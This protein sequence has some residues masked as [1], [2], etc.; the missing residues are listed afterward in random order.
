MPRSGVF[1]LVLCA[2]ATSFVAGAQDLAASYFAP[3]N[4]L[5]FKAVFPDGTVREFE[6]QNASDGLLLRSVGGWSGTVSP[7]GM[8]ELRGAGADG[9]CQSWTYDR[10]RLTRMS[11]GG[12]V[13]T[14][15]YDAPRVAPP[16]PYEPL[17]VLEYENAA[18]DAKEY[19]RQELSG[20]WSGTGRLAF[21]YVN[22]NHSG[23][24]Y[25]GLALLALLLS[26]S[27]SCWARAAGYAMFVGFAVL[28]LL[29]QS[30]G[31]LLGLGT[32]AAVFIMPRIGSVIRSRRFWAAVAVLAVVLAAWFCVF[33]QG[34]WSRGFSGGALD[35]SNAVRVD[36]WMAAPRMM[37]DAP[38]GW[39]FCGA[40][41]A[42]MGWYMPS[43]AYCLTGSLMNDHL[44]LMTDHGWCFR[45]MYLFVVFC[46]FGAGWLALRVRGN[47]VPLSVF[48]A[49]AVMIW[50]N[51]ALDEPGLSAIPVIAT[52]LSLPAVRRIRKRPA[53]KFLCSA[54]LA[55]AVVCGS[56]FV[57]GSNSP[58]RGDQVAVY[59]DG[60]RVLI[61]GKNPEIWVVDDGRGA[62]G[63]VLVARDI[64]DF[65]LSQP[66]V[67]SMGLVRSIDDLPERGISR[68]VLAGKAANDWLLKLSEDESYRRYLPKSVVF[69]SPPFNPS[70]VPSAVVALCRPVLVVGEFAALFRDEYSGSL[71]PWVKVIP[72]MEK[73]IM[74]WPGYALGE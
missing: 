1:P 60:N 3:E 48:S 42:F 4:Q 46:L 24:L 49:Y 22:P 55:S 47:A 20:K 10:G 18:R 69:V 68:L 67:P 28:V 52:C 19:S 58:R 32:G 2:L 25:V 72:G 51:P 39:G 40:G 43:S 53:V 31:S 41:H 6:R 29:T 50:F 57:M 11:V 74:Q 23:C 14:W 13:K 5:I 35:W 73:Y 70:E 56:I 62:L 27:S 38:G 15:G 61:N 34:M 66:S 33:G 9:A 36:M 59:A 30:R 63:G 8:A 54:S 65:Y 12:T 21:P 7:E 17:A 64:R 45:W 16:C 26:M 37:A 44:T 71:P